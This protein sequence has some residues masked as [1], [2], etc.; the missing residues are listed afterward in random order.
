MSAVSVPAIVMFLTIVM[1]SLIVT[2]WAAG[3]TRTADDFY[4]A[5]RS[6]TGF[7]NGLA[8]AGDFMS[9]AT[10]L[11][12]TG[13]FFVFGFDASIYQLAPVVAFPCLLFL[14]A[15]RL[16]NLGR[17]TFSDV[18]SYRFERVPIRS[19][20][21]ISTLAVVIF[22]LIAQ[23][24]GAGALIEV[25][26][27]LPYWIAV[28]LVGVL[29]IVYVAFGGMIA[30]TWVQIIKAV[31]LILGITALGLMVLSVYDFDLG[32][33]YAEARAKH[34]NG[35]LLVTPGGRFPDLV[36]ALS[37]GAALMF[38]I[39]GLPHILMR[40]FT[41]P[42]SSEARRSV[43]YA[44]GFI[45]FVFIVVFFVVAFGAVAMVFGNPDFLDANGHVR[46]GGN[47]AAIHL[48]RIVGGDLFF[49]F[50]SAVAFSTILA[51]VAGL[52]LAGATAVSHD[53]Y[54]NVFRHG[55][56]SE[57]DEVRVS[58]L[59]AIGI[60]LVTIA[61]G[62]LFEKQNIAYLVSLALV[63]SASANFPTLFLCLF[64]RGLT[65]RGA[66][67]GGYLGLTSAIGLM[68][69]GPTVWVGMLGNSEPVFPYLY[70]G[71]FSITLAFAAAWLFSV[72]D[73]SERASREREAF[74]EQ[75]VRAETGLGSEAAAP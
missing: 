16:H 44:T 27:G 20:A 1:V 22:Y 13:L 46:G 39:A 68:I 64:W 45:S 2:Y 26:F 58:R 25:L 72:T 38:G 61:L 31:L 63:V 9:A 36:S 18:V 57:A 37:L 23:V 8:I 40:I 51:V 14:M 66:I 47:M 54:A 29:M 21:A 50:M 62:I 60:G 19:Y 12:I 59:T 56:A 67:A 30:T 5:G 11:G 75:Y 49:G 7:Q 10:F 53:L 65:T 3:R 74:E 34:S 70:P 15:E 17:Y 35:A 69:L 41:V 28:V 55:R 52:T 71:L 48:S 6:I 32:A 73:R 43:V 42:T 33:L 4:A 24:V